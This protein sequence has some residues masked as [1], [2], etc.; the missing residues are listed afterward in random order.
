VS[1]QLTDGQRFRMLAVI[2][3]RTRECLCLVADASLS[4][5]RVACELDTLVAE[6]SEP[7]EPRTIISDKANEFTSN[8]ILCWANRSS[9]ARHYLSLG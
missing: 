4:G 8:T 9:V 3:E 7:S 6:P 2:G 1:D 5:M